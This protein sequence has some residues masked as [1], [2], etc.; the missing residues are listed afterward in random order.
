[1]IVIP[2]SHAIGGRKTDLRYAG[3]SSG[4]SRTANDLHSART[5]HSQ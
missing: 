4:V 3:I 1:M 5:I 2:N